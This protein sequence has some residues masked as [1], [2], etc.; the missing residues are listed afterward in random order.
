MSGQYQTSIVSF[1]SPGWKDSITKCDGPIIAQTIKKKKKKK[2]TTTKAIKNDNNIISVQE[3]SGDDTGITSCYTYPKSLNIQDSS[4]TTKMATTDT[5]DQSKTTIRIRTTHSRRKT[6]ENISDKKRQ[7]I[8]DKKD[9]C[10]S[11]K[12]YSLLTSGN[13]NNFHSNTLSLSTNNSNDDQNEEE[14]SEYEKLRLRNIAR[15]EARIAALGLSSYLPKQPQ[16]I[17]KKTKT[18]PKVVV[19]KQPI[20]RSKRVQNQPPLLTTIDT[21]DTTST[22]TITTTAAVVE[23]E[24]E[25]VISPLV[26]QYTIQKSDFSKDA[27][28]EKR[29]IQPMMN[30]SY[31]C[32]QDKL[33]IP[34][35]SLMGGGI[36][37]LEF[38]ESSPSSS[39]LV[40]AGKSGFISIWNTSSNNIDNNGSSMSWKGH[41]GRWIAHAQMIKENKVVSAGNDGCICIWDVSFISAKTKQPKLLSKTK[42]HSNGIF[43]MHISTMNNMMATGSKDKTI[44]V[45]NIFRDTPI[46]KSAFHSSKVSSVCLQ[47]QESSLLA[48]TS[49]T[50]IAIHDIR[51]SSSEQP[52]IVLEYPQTQHSVLWDPSNTHHLL[53]CGLDTMKLWDIRKAS[54]TSIQTYITPKNKK[55]HKPV[56]YHQDNKYIICGNDLGTIHMYDKQSAKLTSSGN[57]NHVGCLGVHQHQLAV[58]SNDQVLLLQ[59]Q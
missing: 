14:L 33:E 48:S 22:A 58:A 4:S 52:S 24:E 50:T 21:T 51:C 20:R 23:E 11:E 39:W 49:D 29:I 53:T 17:K 31:L 5:L 12:Q 56:F 13:S 26:Q 34:C 25:F 7:R 6:Q 19:P 3:K 9:T 18:K 41:S 55:I 27:K 57:L 38:F 1:F 43:S 28:E 35:P 36:Y 37:S 2:E 16:P 42:Y 59:S 15:N 40:G 32:V 54:S 10:S 46:W 30:G 47:Q 8:L 44:C 45:S